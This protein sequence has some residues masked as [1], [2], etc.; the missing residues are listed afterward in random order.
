M[1]I[2]FPKYFIFTSFLFVSEINMHGKRRCWECFLVIS[3]FPGLPFFHKHRGCLSS[4][5]L[6]IQTLTLPFLSTLTSASLHLPPSHP[7]S[8]QPSTGRSPE[9]FAVTWQQW[10]SANR[11]QNSSRHQ[12]EQLHPESKRGNKK[13]GKW[14]FLSMVFYPRLCCSPES[15]TP[16]FYHHLVKIASNWRVS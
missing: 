10:Q 12:K 7:A 2:A 9:G 6:Y 11:K 13:G 15:P 4:P 3:M 5:G 1:F 14:L 8:G 16:N